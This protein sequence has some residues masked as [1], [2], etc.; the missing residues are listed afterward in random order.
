MSTMNQGLALAIEK[1]IATA[2]AAQPQKAEIRKEKFTA[3]DVVTVYEPG[4]A[5]RFETI[6]KPRRYWSTSIAGF[7][8]ALNY[9]KGRVSEPAGP[10]FVT[11]GVN[12]ITAFLGEEDR[13][14]RLMLRFTK[15]TG[16]K[17]LE[18][19]VSYTQEDFI[20]YLREAFGNNVDPGTTIQLIRKIKFRSQNMGDASVDQ[21]RASMRVETLK[22]IS[23]IDGDFPEQLCVAL[24]PFE[25]LFP[26]RIGAL[27]IQ[28]SL[29]LS[30]PKQSFGLVPF[31]GELAV[32]V[33]NSLNAVAE[34]IRKECSGVTVATSTG[35][36]EPAEND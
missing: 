32:A 34:L 6:K 29:R 30:V 12:G 7:C 36:A 2:Q 26:G 24:V 21:G 20:V 1:L 35:V 13:R 14:D 17:A 15:T 28:C 16:Y 4:K 8:E 19:P 11:V 9:L 27:K 22:E 18:T 25:E 10:V 3:K 33:T 31:S 5:P 23:G